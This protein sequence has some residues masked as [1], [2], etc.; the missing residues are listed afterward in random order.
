MQHNS[1]FALLKIT[2][3]IRKAASINNP[4]KGNSAS[5][6]SLSMQNSSLD[7]TVFYLDNG[8]LKMTQGSNGP[9][10]L[11]S[12]DVQVIDLEFSNCSYL[13]TPG[14]IKINLIA[15]YFNP[16][17]RSEYQASVNFQTSASLLPGGAP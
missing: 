13:E 14:I 4:I 11:T 2:Q 12:P 10:S 9:F 6:L 8:V 15:E 7:P 17:G 3:E 5:S 1:R 16:G